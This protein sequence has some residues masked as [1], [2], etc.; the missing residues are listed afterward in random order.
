MY[1]S[2]Q[3]SSELASPTR[4][5]RELPGSHNRSSTPQQ[6]QRSLESIVRNQKPNSAMRTSLST[7][8]AK[9]SPYRRDLI[10]KPMRSITA[11]PIQKA[12]PEKVVG[13]KSYTEGT[14][15]HEVS[16]I[17]KTNDKNMI[18]DTENWDNNGNN[19]TDSDIQAD[20]ETSP[21]HDS[22]LNRMNSFKTTNNSA[23]KRSNKHINSMM[24][25]RTHLTA[26]Y[27]ASIPP[28]QFLSH[29]SQTS[30]DGS[31]IPRP[32]RHTEAS[33]KLPILMVNGSSL[34]S[35]TSSPASKSGKAKDVEDGA[36]GET[37]KSCR[38]VVERSIPPPSTPSLKAS[39]LPRPQSLEKRC[40]KAQPATS[41]PFRIKRHCAPSE[42]TEK[43]LVSGSI[44]ATG[45]IVDSDAQS[46][47]E[48][49][50]DQK[51]LLQEQGLEA[52]I[53]QE[54]PEATTKRQVKMI[55]YRLPKNN[56]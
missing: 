4:I 31:R 11:E 48:G 45:P 1:Q 12:S 13:L 34:I 52:V 56:R 55:M 5:S 10:N 6:V 33:S 23:R 14:F 7:R 42:T 37:N 32:R 41:F 8:H 44:D 29:M 28:K 46:E 38:I 50:A 49:H 25:G 40:R 39:K 35:P 15:A 19:H 36:C 30:L 20:N 9:I 27:L 21:I 17:A 22:G 3:G 26:Q 2:L 16:D 53:Q 54:G 43:D 47:V 51:M 24:G 18:S